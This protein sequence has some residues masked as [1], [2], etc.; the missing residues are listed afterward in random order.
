MRVLLISNGNGEDRITAH[1]GRRWRESRDGLSLQALALV[2]S[3]LFYTQA[4]IPLLPPRFS[5]PSQGFAYLKPHLLL[6]DFQA[7][8]GAHLRKSISCLLEIGPRI[9]FVLAVGD[10]VAVIAASLTGRPFAFFGAALSDHYLGAAGLAGKNSYDPLQRWLLKRKDA[11]VF[12]RDALTAGN[13]R[14]HGLD[15]HFVGNPMRDC[16]E[17]PS[18]NCPY[19]SSSAGDRPL[20]L[21]LPGSHADALANFALTLELLEPSLHAAKDLVVLCAPQL[22]HQDWQGQLRTS[23]WEQSDGHWRRQQGRL[24]L[25]DAVWMAPLLQ[26]AQLAIGL[27]GTANEQCVGAG[28]PVISFATPGAQY[29]WAFGEA[30]QRLLGAGLFFQ[31]QTNAELLARQIGMILAPESAPLIRAR[32]AQVSA[33]R[34]GAAGGDMRMLEMIGARIHALGLA[35]ERRALADV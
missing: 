9:D 35:T 24:W 23:G 31:G 14:R 34:F 28:L 12:G 15:A 13:L 19:S 4:R 33:E 29:T 7:G 27:A 32:L 1:L 17:T 30:Q 2:G 20:I 10:I 6:K 26:Q 21:L 3:G 16:M 11:L 18:G 22:A 25:L 8:L 5:P